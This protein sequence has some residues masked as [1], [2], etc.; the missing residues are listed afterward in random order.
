MP[1]TGMIGKTLMLALN[2]DK[3]AELLQPQSSLFNTA[4]CAPA[5]AHLLLPF[6]D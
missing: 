2:V 6:F 5:A 1:V 4:S 3:P